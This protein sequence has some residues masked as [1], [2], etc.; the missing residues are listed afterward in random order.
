MNRIGIPES[1]QQELLAYL[2]NNY[3][4]EN[5]GIVNR[6]TGRRRRGSKKSSGYLGFNFYFK[7]KGCNSYI[8]R[9]VWALCYNELPTTT[10]DHINGD[11]L[12]NRIENLRE[13]IQSENNLNSLLPWRPNKG[14]GIPGVDLHH[15]RYRTAIRGQGYRFSN[16]YQAFYWAIACGKRYRAS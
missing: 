3:K 1:K 12:D 8:H 11:I 2:K 9:I 4:Y 13:V 15:G 5:G 6:K 7:G 16:P 10:I 14:T